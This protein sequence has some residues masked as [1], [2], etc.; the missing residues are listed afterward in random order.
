MANTAN[1]V[2][3]VVEIHDKSH[4]LSRE[5]TRTFII[6]DARFITLK[7]YYKFVMQ[8]LSTK[9]QGIFLYENKYNF[10]RAN[11]HGL[12][13]CRLLSRYKRMYLYIFIKKV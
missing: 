1:M 7:D 11:G 4:A 6:F 8:M 9:K 5:H 2:N 13:P 3:E 12:R 10:I